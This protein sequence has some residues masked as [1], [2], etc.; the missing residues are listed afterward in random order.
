MRDLALALEAVIWPIA[1]VACLGV[2]L[3]AMMVHGPGWEMRGAA[4]IAGYLAVWAIGL[5]RLYPRHPAHL[6]PYYEL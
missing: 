5:V 1:A 4:G 3:Q 6:D 2:A